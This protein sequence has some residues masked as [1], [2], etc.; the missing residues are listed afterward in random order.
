MAKSVFLPAKADAVIYYADLVRAL[1][2]YPRFHFIEMG[3]STSGIIPVG[4][5]DFRKVTKR[6]VTFFQNPGKPDFQNVEI[7]LYYD[8]MWHTWIPLYA[9]VYGE[10]WSL[11]LSA[12]FLHDES[13]YR[14][15][16]VPAEVDSIKWITLMR[17]ERQ[18]YIKYLVPEIHLEVPAGRSAYPQH[19]WY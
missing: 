6:A 7:Q 15:A 16:F 4:S 2:L 19:H 5:D 11:D 10:G 8:L 3:Q 14:Y 12:F 18:E 9:I 1:G 13:W 17:S